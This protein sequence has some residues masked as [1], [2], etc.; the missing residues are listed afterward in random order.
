MGTNEFPMN[1]HYIHISIARYFTAHTCFTLTRRPESIDSSWTV[2]AFWL[3][4]K[5]VV[6]LHSSDDHSPLHCLGQRLF[7]GQSNF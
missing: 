1:I 6:P 7:C 3:T 2:S 5:S 4:Y